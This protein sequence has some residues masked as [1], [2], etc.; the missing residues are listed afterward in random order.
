[1]SSNWPHRVILAAAACAA[2]AVVASEPRQHVSLSLSPEGR[3][4][5][6]RLGIKMMPVR[7]GKFLMGSPAGEAN[8]N[9]DEHQHEVELTRDFY[10]AAHETTQKQ[11]AAVTGKNPSHFKKT[12]NG[13]GQVQGM[14]TDDFPVDTVSWEEA[15][16]F[17]DK[18]NEREPKQG[19]KYAL[20]T[21]A[22]WEYACR[23]GPESTTKPFRFDAPS[24]SISFG[25]ASFSGQAYGGGKNGANPGRTSKVGSYK[26]NNLGLH[27]MHGNLWEWCADWYDAGYPKVSPPRDPAG[28]A[29]GTQKMLR[30]GCHFNTGWELRAGRRHGQPAAFKNEAVGFRVAMVRVN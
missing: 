6:S 14:D 12:G 17:V 23:G 25:Q 22:Q 7:K 8:R 27:D 9:D 15:Q 21:E 28:P 1:M 2:L 20:P 13:G 29:K 10:L 24:D 4:F 11:Y 18:L 26:P 3:A 5:T 19:W 16:A 30:S